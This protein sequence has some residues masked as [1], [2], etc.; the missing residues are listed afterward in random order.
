M[1]RARATAATKTVM[2]SSTSLNMS[3]GG[4]T[5]LDG[6]HLRSTDF[7]LPE[8]NAIVT[9]AQLLELVESR[10]SSSLF[11]LSLSE[12][13]KSSTL[14]CLNIANGTHMRSS[15]FSLSEPNAIVIGAQLLE[16]AESRASS[17]LFGLSL[18]ENL[19]SS[20][21]KRLNIADDVFF[22]I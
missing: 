5:V 14:K 21:L 16:L 19:K 3:D 2:P 6:T 18:P 22:Q 7:S 13:L 15:D 12:N 10:A 9:G 20:A 4:L 11:G 8:P 17:S 1:W